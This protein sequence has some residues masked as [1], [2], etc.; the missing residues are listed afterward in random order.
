[1]MDFIY[2]LFRLFNAASEIFGS[3][4]LPVV[5]ISNKPDNGYPEMRVW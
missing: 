3:F 4:L 5:L 2:F 1:M